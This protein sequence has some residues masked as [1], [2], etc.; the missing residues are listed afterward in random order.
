MY[1][2]FHKQMTKQLGQL[3]TMLDMA[4][5]F[6]KTK[7]FVPKV[8]LELR[9]APDQFSFVR[10]VQSACDTAKL[11]AARLTGKTAPSHPDTETTMAELH[12]RLR[13]VISYLE[14]FS[15]ADYDGA[16]ERLITTPRWEGEVM[17]GS[18][19]LVEHAL[20]NFFFHLNHAYAILRH[21][22]VDVGKRHYLG[23]IS[24]KKP[25]T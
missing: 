8:L 4:E 10:Q 16:A 1:H 22:G 18:D 2:Q 23:A 20:P 3:D 13:S 15:A 14:T 11:A 12:A 6:A 19:Y 7:P 24:R 25:G 21:S 17:T 9:L 5:A